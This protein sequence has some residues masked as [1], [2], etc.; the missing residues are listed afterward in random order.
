[1]ADSGD[2]PMC[3]SCLEHAY[4]EPAFRSLNS[5]STFALCYLDL[6]RAAHHG[7]RF[8]RALLAYM[9]HTFLGDVESMNDET[10]LEVYLNVKRW[11]S[12]L[13]ASDPDEDWHEH[14]GYLTFKILDHD[15]GRKLQSDYGTNE[16]LVLLAAEGDEP[17]VVMIFLTL[18]GRRCFSG[19]RQSSR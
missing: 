11:F 6:Q 1:M 18:S 16:V 3:A 19:V 14:L 7:C 12:E 5:V 13:V 15:Q 8:C 9:V 2:P 4:K 10:I 17:Y